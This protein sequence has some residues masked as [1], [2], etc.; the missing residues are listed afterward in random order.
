[1]RLVDRLKD[2]V[3]SG[4]EWISSVDM[5]RAL[6][7]HP[8]VLEA[9]VIAVPDAHWGERPLAILA[10]KAGAEATDQQI[11]EHLLTR[12][13]KWMVPEHISFVP[14]LPKTSVGK[15]NKQ[16]LRTQFAA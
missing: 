13:P 1:M 16:M 7:E 2:L 12:F 9:A 11:R 6:C 15:L 8:A 5:E 10:L 4:G 3:K 14:T